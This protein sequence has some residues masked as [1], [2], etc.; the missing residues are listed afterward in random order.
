MRSAVFFAVL[1]AAFPV[2]ADLYRWI[3]PQSGSVKY[4]SVPPPWLGDPE[5]EARSPRVEVISVRPAGARVPADNPAA[6]RPAASLEVS[7]RAMLRELSLL[8]QRAD[9]DRSG[10]AIQ[11]QLRAYETLRAEL[12]RTD[13]PGA[14]RRRAEESSVMEQ[15]KRGL[16][17]QLR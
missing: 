17:A 7:W 1:F 4:S 13:P 14:A 12:D 10:V 5:R 15:I 9:L 16:G 8:P 2:Q 3:D 11:Q 6:P